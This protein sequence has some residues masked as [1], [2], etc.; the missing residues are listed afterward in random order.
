MLIS[1]V[2]KS[3]SGKSFI[4]KELESYSQN[5]KHLNIDQISHFVLE[6][7]DVKEKLITTFGQNIITDGEVNRKKLGNLVFNSTEKMNQLTDITWQRME[8]IIDAYILSNKDK[9]IILDWQLLPKTK[10]FH[11]SDLKVLVDAPTEIRKLRTLKRDNITEEKFLEREKASINFNKEEFDY[12]IDN[13]NFEST[14]GKVKNLYDQSI[15]S[16]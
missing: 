3:G 5:I 8:K 2:G 9:I 7:D 16:G 4:S 12:V 1:I 6:L 14:K 15:I 13:N 11:Q 10:Y